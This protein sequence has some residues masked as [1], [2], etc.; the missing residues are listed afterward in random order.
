MVAAGQSLSE[1]KEAKLFINWDV[2]MGYFRV[3]VQSYELILFTGLQSSGTSPFCLASDLLPL[4]LF[5]I[6]CFCFPSCVADPCEWLLHSSCLSTDIPHVFFLV[7]C[8]CKLG[9]NCFL[10]VWQKVCMSRLNT[11][12]SHEHFTPTLFF[13][14]K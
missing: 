5:V 11:F 13:C 2:K 7:S 1:V 4:P 10:D 14:P 12:T 6:V 3:I 8:S 9:H